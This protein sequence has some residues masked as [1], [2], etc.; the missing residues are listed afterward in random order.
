MI[1]EFCPLY[2]QQKEKESES[3]TLKFMESSGSFIVKEF[4]DL[5]TIKVN[6]CKIK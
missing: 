2:A 6:G 5:G 3:I 1:V 4:Y